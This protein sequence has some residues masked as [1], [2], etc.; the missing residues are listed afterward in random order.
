MNKHV[1][2]GIISM[3]ILCFL[4]LALLLIFPETAAEGGRNGL[5]LWATVLVPSLLPFSILTSL[6]RKKLRG[7]RLCYLLLTAGVLSGYPIG[8]K[9]AG[10]L[11]NDG[12]LTK[13]Q[14]VFF[15]GA[16]NN[17]SPMFVIFFVGESLLH[18]GSG[19]Y[20]FYLTVLLS[21]VLGS[22]FFYLLSPLFQGKF[23]LHVTSTGHPPVP[24]ATFSEQLD[25][26]ISASALLLIKIGGYIMLFSILAKMIQSLPGLPPIFQIPLCGLLEITTGNAMICGAGIPHHAKI[27]L[28]L[29][30]TAFGGLSAAAQTNSVLRNTGLS[31]VPYVIIKLFGSLFALLLGFL[32]W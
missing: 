20:F 5:V 24:S 32:L 18:L 13:K 7:N 15:S 23:S 16:I 30:F 26:E 29:A 3:L 22:V 19:K 28:C 10:D 1:L 8:A 31:I 12:S 17:P 21:A 2:W 27:I 14:A 11:Y 9:I 4:L 25:E 6:L